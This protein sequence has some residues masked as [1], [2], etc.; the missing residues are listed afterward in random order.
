[1][2]ATKADGIHVSRAARGGRVLSN[3]VWDSEDDGI[4][5]VSYRPDVQASGVVIEGNSVGHIRWGRGI[6]VV[7]SKDI[8]IRR[9]SIRSVAMAAGIIV[10]REAFWNTHGAANVLIEE[11]DISDIQ[12]SLKPLDGRK[13]TAQAAIDINSDSTEPALA[14]TDVRIVANAV[15][16]SGYD[17]IRLNGNVR[18]ISIS[19]NDLQGI[20]RAN[21]TVVN[22]PPGQHIACTEE[23]AAAA[24]SQPCAI[25]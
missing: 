22:G 14:V 3:S 9:N 16:G 2:S 17:G 23:A 13:R 12:Q 18:R 1:V 6:A 24:T 19:G 5:V 10:G 21:L 20:A 7:G 15:R 11:N 25:D 4:A 8:V